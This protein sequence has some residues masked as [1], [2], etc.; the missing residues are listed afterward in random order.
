MAVFIA[1]GA[2]DN[3]D[4]DQSEKM[5]KKFAGAKGNDKRMELHK[6]AR[7]KFRGTDMLRLG[8]EI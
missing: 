7:V 5:F 8:G 4:D 3:L 1:Y 2:E 6:Y